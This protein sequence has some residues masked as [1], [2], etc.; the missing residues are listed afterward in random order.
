[1]KICMV[2]NVEWILWRWVP[3]QPEWISR[4]FEVWIEGL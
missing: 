2:E 3:K 1:M 4:D